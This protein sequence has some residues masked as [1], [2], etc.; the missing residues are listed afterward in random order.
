M[1]LCLYDQ[2]VFIRDTHIRDN[3]HSFAIFAIYLS[4]T[5]ILKLIE[6]VD[7]AIYLISFPGL[8]DSVQHQLHPPPRVSAVFHLH[9]G[10][11]QV[12]QLRKLHSGSSRALLNKYQIGIETV[13]KEFEAA[14]WHANSIHVFAQLIR[15]DGTRTCIDNGNK[16]TRRSGET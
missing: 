4:K 13:L 8:A 2:L 16:L 12:L 9:L 14:S 5:Y 1:K 3:G 7:N 6:V 11:S 15:K 10:T